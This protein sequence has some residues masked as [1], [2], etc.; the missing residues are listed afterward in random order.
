MTYETLLQELVDL[1]K[2]VAGP[3]LGKKFQVTLTWL[4]GVIR[5]ILLICT[6]RVNKRVAPRRSK[7]ELYIYNFVCLSASVCSV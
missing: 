3:E 2:V 7:P 4:K 6:C 1:C 5:Q